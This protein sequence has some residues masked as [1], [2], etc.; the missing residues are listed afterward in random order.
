MF[1]RSLSNQR[2]VCL[3]QPLLHALNRDQSRA[4]KLGTSLDNDLGKRHRRR[5]T[6]RPWHA[7]TAVLSAIGILVVAAV[8]LP[9]WNLLRGPIAH[10][11]SSRL[12]RTVSIDG[13][14]KVRVSL[15][16]EIEVNGLA[17][18]NASWGTH[19]TMVQIE[20]ARFRIDLA[21]LFRG[22]IVVPQAQLLRASVVLER[23]SEATPNWEFREGRPGGGSA[24]EIGSLIIQESELVYEDPSV[25]TKVRL[26]IES[27]TPSQQG[28]VPTIRLAGSGSLRE[29][30]FQIEG[31]AETLLSLAH[32]GRP[33]Q[34]AV[35]AIAG[36]TKV[37]FAGTLLPFKLETIDGNL[38]VGG[39]D[40]SK[41]YPIVPVPLPWTPPYRLSGRL[42]REGG[43]WSFRG[44]KGLVG[45]SDIAGDFSLNRKGKRPTI[46]ADVT[47]RRLDYKDLI[48]F[49]GVPPKA[50]SQ[51]RPPDQ[52]LEAAKRA[53]TER[54]LP[55]KAYDLGRLRA[56]DGEVRFRGKSVV[57]RDIPLDNVTAH[58]ILKEGK[59]R[60]VP[61]DF[62]VADGHVV[63]EITLD[64]G[65]SVIDTAADVTITNVD[66]KIL[67]PELKAN[68]AS[69]GRLGG[70]AKLS[71]TGNSIA[72]M[73][74]SADGELAIAMSKGRLSTLSLLLT[75]L[76]LANAAELLL[77]GDRNAPVYCAVVSG[78]IHDGDFVPQLL[79]VDSSEEKITG[80]GEIDFSDERYNLRLKAQS[81]RPSLVALR[82]P[83]RI[84]GTFKHPKVAPEA[85]P[86]VV[87][88]A[89]A[90]ALG[91]VLT[92]PA[93]LL[94]LADPGDARDSDCAA[95][96]ARGE[97]TVADGPDSIVRKAVAA[98]DR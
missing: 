11:L 36:D 42:V 10:Y 13:D 20:R 72:Q 6:L 2:G 21:P 14:L 32:Q 65:R 5:F 82:G 88:V 19:P 59:L 48:G 40:L 87:R 51:R 71:A 56:V 74:A 50:R 24:P 63:S 44:F 27:D 97:K 12:N 3:A 17:V 33:Y 18:G 62:G 58:L 38:Q 77:R 91:A 94:A 31:H 73:S 78:R 93:A 53:A 45:A 84:E 39:K 8:A 85:G 7:I 69:A 76:D 90:I 54:V 55:S 68:E 70:R 41:L 60:F 81:K 98:T 64:A 49:L 4:R 34:L 79:V 16:P 52:K 37:S 30:A 9:N 26:A 96:L 86:V 47:S 22:R 15:Q 25:E 46:S 66:V 83:I 57:A 95:L 23:N 92:P 61:L 35:Q 43:T 28:G 67:F 1:A 75:N 89:A 80:E 29:E